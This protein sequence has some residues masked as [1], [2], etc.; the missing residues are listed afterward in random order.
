MASETSVFSIGR[1]ACRAIPTG[2]PK[3]NPSRS[4]RARSVIQTLQV[5]E[6]SDHRD[7]ER[8]DEKSFAYIK[9]FLPRKVLF[10]RQVRARAPARADT[11]IASAPQPSPAHRTPSGS[12]SGTRSAE[13]HERRCAPPYSPCG[14][15]SPS[16]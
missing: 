1:F 11:E 14:R 2:E 5:S 3:T 15:R 9:H 10:E 6:S 4:A 8:I 16:W 13:A 12:R 7:E